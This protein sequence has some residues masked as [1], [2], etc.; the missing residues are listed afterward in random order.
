MIDARRAGPAAA[1][2]RIYMFVCALF[3][4][5]TPYDREGSAAGPAGALG[6]GALAP[7][8]RRRPALCLF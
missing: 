6:R 1:A 5:L 7:S 4:R 2:D 3:N 8:P